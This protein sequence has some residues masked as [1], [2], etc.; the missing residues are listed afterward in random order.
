M[1]NQVCIINFH[2]LG[3][4]PLGLSPGEKDCWLDQSFFEAILDAVRERKDVP[5]TL[6][7]SN[8]SDYTIAFAALQARNMRAKFFAVAQRLDQKRYLSTGQLQAMATAGMGIGTHGMCHRR[9]TELNTKDLHEELV[10]AKDR[11]EQVL[12]RPVREAACPYGSYNRRVLGSLRDLGYERI[13]TSDEGPALEDAL[14]QPRNTIR[15]THNLAHVHR[16][17]GGG[18]NGFKKVLRDIKLKLKQL[19]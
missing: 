16:I 8:E 4:V 12:G 13:Y 19:R 9:W 7:D 10:E 18:P 6:D 2:G 1:S 14:I 5:I 11:L 3:P 15:R 17:T